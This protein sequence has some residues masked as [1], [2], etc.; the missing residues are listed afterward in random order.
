MVAIDAKWNGSFWEVY[1]HGGRKPRGGI[2]AVEWARKV[3]ELG[4]GRYS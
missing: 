2:D 3:E 4:A 1:T